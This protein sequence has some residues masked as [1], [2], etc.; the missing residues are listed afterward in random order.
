MQSS[1]HHRSFLIYNRSYGPINYLWYTSNYGHCLLHS[2]GDSRSVCSIQPALS[3]QTTKKFGLSCTC[4]GSF[5]SV[6]LVDDSRLQISP[7]LPQLTL[8]KESLLLPWTVVCRL[9]RHFTAGKFPDHY[10]RISSKTRQ[11]RI[12]LTAGCFFIPIILFFAPLLVFNN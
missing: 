6:P 4:P 7:L 11:K 12:L 1:S 10:L 2:Q 5:S 8:P 9:R 3:L